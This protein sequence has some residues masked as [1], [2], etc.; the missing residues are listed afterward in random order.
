M[1]EERLQKILAA[2]GYGSRRTCETLIL[3]GVVTVNGSVVTQLGSK[4]DADKDD[5]RVGR[6]RIRA[7][8]KVHLL[9]NKPAGYTTTRR[10]PHATRTVIELIANVAERV[11]PVGRLDADTEGVLLFTN[12]GELANRL[13]HPRYGVKKTYRARVRGL[14]TPNVIEKL[15]VG[16]RINGERTGPAD[17]KLVSSHPETDN[18][19]VELTLREGKK[20][21][22]K[23]MMRAVGHP[24]RSLRRLSFAG[25]TTSGVPEGCYRYLKPGEVARLRKL[26]ELT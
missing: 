9:L 23:E 6:Q 13:T 2:A 20:R 14:V 18:S 21:Q 8:A 17:V 19:V 10:D 15:K 25:L 7:E 26:C 16:V 12:D 11:N 24:V 1:A 22:V 3:E 5:I 4:A